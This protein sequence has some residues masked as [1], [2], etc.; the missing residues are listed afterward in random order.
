MTSTRSKSPKIALLN[1][2][3]APLAARIRERYPDLELVTCDNYDAMA[4]LVPSEKPEVV[5]A[6][7][8]GTSGTFPRDPILGTDSVKWIQASG[9]GI[10]HW[11]PWDP[12]RV[13]L[14]NASG[15]HGDVMSEFVVWAMLNHQLG[16]PAYASQQKEKVWQ[17][18]LLM[19]V[20][21]LT[22]SIIGFGAI[23]EEVGRVAKAL[24]MHVLAVRAHPRPSPHADEVVGLDAMNDVLGQSDYVHLVLPLTPDTRGI[25]DADVLAA[26]KPGAY[27]INTGRGGLVDEDA[28]ITCLNNGH[29]SGAAID[30]FAKEPLPADSPFWTM[31]NVIITP[32]ASGDASDWHMRVADLF[33]DNLGRW[34]ADEP[35]NN[36][37]D[38]SR[39]Y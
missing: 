19:P 34:L 27:F 36:I 5:L 10:D 28:L 9:A 30:V 22:L 38:P 3:P 24:G 21:G 13:F 26:I 39:G 16:M 20:T 33:C 12:D 37:V 23:G 6:F 2:D 14:T 32:H 29:I 25:I 8:V 11:M 15:I 35:L 18:N 1:P 4:E 7:K 17:K 31:D